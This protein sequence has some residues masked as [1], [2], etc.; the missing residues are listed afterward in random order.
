MQYYILAFAA[1]LLLA[2]D[3]S[4]N[5]LY[6][7]RAGSSAAAGFAFNALCGIFTAIVFWAINGFKF[8]FTPFSLVMATAMA[9]SVLL[10][11]LAGLKMLSGGRLAV[12]TLFLMTGGMSLPYIF[13]LIF[14]N[15]PFSVLRT[16]GILLI[17]AGVICANISKKRGSDSRGGLYLLLGVIVF[18]LNG[19]ASIISKSHQ[20]DTAHATVSAASFVMLVGLMRA[21]TC[22]AAFAVCAKKD[23]AAAKELPLLHAV[24]IT[25][26]S[27]VISGA[28]Y[29]FQLIG[30]ANLPATVL[31]PIVTGGS[32]V[33]TTLAGWLL[34]REKPPAR[35][36][37]GV[38]LCLAGTLLFL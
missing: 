28:S 24:P 4:L 27:A 38:L 9:T 37:I 13:G 14:W 16:A 1:T 2:T 30:A 8:E 20:I 15:E 29:L 33:F 22:A 21:V 31:Y 5:K 12:Y 25:A 19:C 11:S 7:R 6:Q 34:F 32:I 36:W 10:Y 18:V 26:A 23:H 3:F 35:T 17:T